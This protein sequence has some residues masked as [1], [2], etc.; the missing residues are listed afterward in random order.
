M[1]AARSH[2]GCTAQIAY[3]GSAACT[4]AAVLLAPATV[5]MPPTPHPAAVLPAAPTQAVLPAPLAAAVAGAYPRVCRFSDGRRRDDGLGGAEQG[6][7]EQAWYVDDSRPQTCGPGASSASSALSLSW[8]LTAGRPTPFH[9][10]QARSAA[11]SAR[12]RMRMC[13][14]SRTSTR[15]DHVPVNT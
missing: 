12:S 15:C 10:C 4:L 11:P 9:V 8:F 5:A 7:Q 13:A 14:S 1:A 6:T 3:H 2:R